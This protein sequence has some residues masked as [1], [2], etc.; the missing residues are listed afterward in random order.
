M[1]GVKPEVDA[2]E[3]AREAFTSRYSTARVAFLA[4]S[5]VRGDATASSDLDMVVVYDQLPRAYRESFYHRGWPVEAFVHDRETLNYFFSEV[6]GASGR[7]S[8]PSMVLEGI[9]IPHASAFSDSLK[10]LARTVV[11]SGPPRLTEEDLRNLRYAV[12]DLLED[13][14]E[15]RSRGE[16]VASAA[17]LYASLADFYLRSRNSWSAAAKWIPRRLLEVDP[18]LHARFIAAFNRLFR[19]GAQDDVLG[20]A[21]EL[22][23]PYGGPL[24]QG[25]RRD[26][27]ATYRKP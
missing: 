5:V 23:A 9:A 15:P 12:T 27:P 4:G 20:L 18:P 11:D 24:F 8:L 10:A 19:D 14:R 26:A 3:A 21:T 16:L 13:I 22:M 1:T 25:Y 17:A 6:D 2:Q 7:P